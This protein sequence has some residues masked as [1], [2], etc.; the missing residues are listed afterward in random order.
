MN[1]PRCIEGTADTGPHRG[2]GPHSVALPADGAQQSPRLR[3]VESA[4]DHRGREAAYARRA[5]SDRGLTRPR[6][7]LQ[8]PGC[9][10]GVAG[11]FTGPAWGI[12]LHHRL[13]P[14]GALWRDARLVPRRPGT[15]MN[16]PPAA[17][18]QGLPEAVPGARTRDALQVSGTAA[19]PG[20]GAG[21]AL[22]RSRHDRGGDASGWP[23]TRGRPRG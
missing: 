6:G 12:T 20:P 19:L 18:H 13:R 9:A 2:T 16:I 10:P 7:G 23:F 11:R 5:S 8:V 3:E 15:S 4:H 22:G 17:R 21:G 1:T 14:Q